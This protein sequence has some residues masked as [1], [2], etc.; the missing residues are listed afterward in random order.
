VAGPRSFVVIRFN[1]A[2][3][4][5][6]SH[7]LKHSHRIVVNAIEYRWR[8]IGGDGWIKLAIW[9]SNGVGQAIGCGFGYHETVESQIVITNRLV[10]RVILH[11]IDAESYNPN[12]AGIQLTI[13]DIEDK[14]DWSDAVRAKRITRRS[15]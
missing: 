12:A 4:P 6:M 15:T 13:R 9:P 11:S 5:Q 1:F 10:R 2:Q 7:S 3:A 14:I 8:A